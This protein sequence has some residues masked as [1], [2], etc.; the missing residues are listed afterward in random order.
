MFVSQSTKKTS[1]V[2]ESF[3]LI[4]RKFKCVD[5]VW[6]SLKEILSWG[7]IVFSME[8]SQKLVSVQCTGAETS[9]FKWG[10][11]S[12]KICVKH[13]CISIYQENKLI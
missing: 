9:R 12:I 5:E 10:K 2:G 4:F 13:V 3:L 7:K 11:V 8:L 6:K 1:S